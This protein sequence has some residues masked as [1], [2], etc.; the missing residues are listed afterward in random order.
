MT[1]L[2]TG[3]GGFVAAHLIDELC[4]LG[5]GPVIAADV[6][7]PPRDQLAA[8]GDRVRPVTLDVT[9]LAD[10]KRVVAET[11]P[12]L[13]VHGAA[14]T[15]DLDEERQSPGQ[16]CA[17]NFGGSANL[18]E[19]C[20]QSPDVRRV[21]L[22]SSSGVYNGLEPYPPTLKE[23]GELP[24]LPSSL[25]AVTKI[26]CE[27]LAARA[28]ATTGLSVAAI[29]VAAVYGHH[30][31]A[32]HSRRFPRT[33][34]IHRLASALQNNEELQAGGEDVGRD[35]LHGDDAARAIVALLTA[36]VLNHLVYNVGSGRLSGWHD[37]LE[38]FSAAGLRTRQATTSS[39]FVM[40]QGDGRPPLDIQRLAADT[41]F[42]PR[43]DIISGI[44]DLVSRQRRGERS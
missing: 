33:S 22:F 24:A 4:R 25:Y 26:A 18:I 44:R 6:S 3:A 21:I 27:G 41:G 5:L 37:I 43:I 8:W 38:T 17:V 7:A 39:P 14:I 1:V 31:R 34:L 11:R 13:V 32:T 36:P 20:Q 10:V 30:E 15:P 16:I 35:W 28:R 19:A 29:R 23:D 40:V 9:N 42:A 12:D 2:V